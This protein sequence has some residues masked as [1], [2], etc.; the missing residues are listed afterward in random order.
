MLAA[1]KHPEQSAVW[2]EH[3]VSPHC[4]PQDTAVPLPAG[5]GPDSPL[6]GFEERTVPD[7][8]SSQ[9]VFH[10][11]TW[12][13]KVSLILQG[14]WRQMQTFYACQNAPLLP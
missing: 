13:L 6:T 14:N 4:H 11:D 3:S 9:P 2:W 10:M 5:P 7:P 12:T 8:I 1:G